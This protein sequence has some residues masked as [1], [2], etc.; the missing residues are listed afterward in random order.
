MTNLTR[1]NQKV[2][3]ANALN[4]GQFG[5]LQAT[6]KIL[7]SDIETLQALPAYDN[8][9]NDAIVS[10][11][12]LPSLEEF[13]ALNYINT[14]QI[15][16][17]QQKGIPEWHIDTTYYIGDITREVAG[18][19]LYKSSIDDNSGL[20]IAATAYNAG[21][22]YEIDDVAMDTNGDIYR[23]LTG[24]NIGN[25]LTD[26]VNWEL[27]WTFLLD[28][29]IAVP[30]ASET[31]KGIAEIATQA[32]TNA[33]TDDVR[34]ITPLKLKNLPGHIVQ[35]VNT[36]TGAVATGTT[37]MVDD[38]TIPQNT[39]GDEFMSLSITPTSAT[40]KLKIDIVANFST[41]A[42]TDVMTGLFQDSTANALAAFRTG[43]SS[44]GKGL[45]VIFTH[46][47]TAGTT[48]STTFKVRIGTDAAGTT[49][50]NGDA[51]AR[52]LG[53]VMASSITITEIQA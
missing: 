13:Q 1:K 36:Q 12:Q 15:A 24:G 46:Y 11:E 5:S 50:F 49:T 32:E 25:P 9:W 33:G 31:A 35:V 19:K 17:N 44:T 3:A 18:T 42:G 34:F 27:V 22:T 43:T 28:L 47:M 53:G 8:G 16:Y 45:A 14:Y 7:S 10:G 37:A 6:T 39:E 4:N 21:T 48:S 38:D 40:N 52:R 29:A 2:F 20:D 41:N 26:P 51:G 23:S 30:D